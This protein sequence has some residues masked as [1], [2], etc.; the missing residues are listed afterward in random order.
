[1]SNTHAKVLAFFGGWEPTSI[2]MLAVIE[3]RFTDQTVRKNVGLLQTAG[4]AAARSN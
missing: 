1:M 4:C 3:K 2:G